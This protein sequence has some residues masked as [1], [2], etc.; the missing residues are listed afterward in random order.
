MSLSICQTDTGYS[1]HQTNDLRAHKSALLQTRVLQ[2]L[3]PSSKSL[4]PQILTRT[5]VHRLAYSFEQNLY[6]VEAPLPVG[7]S[8]PFLYQKEPTS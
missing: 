3:C 7:E 8:S 5:A 2:L 6:P 1:S 4:C